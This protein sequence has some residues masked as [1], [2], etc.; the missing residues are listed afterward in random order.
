MHG[1]V[2]P[3]LAAG[4][5]KSTIA[6]TLG[7]K[8]QDLMPY[9]VGLAASDR[10]VVLRDWACASERIELALSIKLQYAPM[11]PYRLSVIALLDESEARYQAITCKHLWATSQG[12][13]DEEFHPLT[14][15]F[16]HGD[17][18]NEFDRFCN[19]EPMRTLPTLRLHRARFRCIPV[20]ERSIEQ[21]HALAKLRLRSNNVPSPAS[22]S[23]ALRLP[24]WIDLVRRSSELF[25]SMSQHVQSIRRLSQFVDV[26]G[27]RT[28]KALNEAFCKQG[29]LRW[30]DVVKVLYH[31]D[32]DTTFHTRAQLENNLRAAEAHKRKAAQKLRKQA[33]A[34]EPPDGLPS[35]SKSPTGPFA[36]Q[37]HHHAV[38]H[39][40]AQSAQGV[41]YSCFLHGAQQ[42]EFF[43]D[44]LCPVTKQ[45]SHQHKVTRDTS[46]QQRQPPES[47]DLPM[48][49]ESEV[50]QMESKQ[51]VSLQLVTGNAMEAFELIRDSSFRAASLLP[52]AMM[53]DV[54][55]EDEQR[56]MHSTPAFVF[57]VLQRNPSSY[58]VIT[59][60]PRMNTL[61]LSDTAIT[62]H[63]AAGFDL[64]A[65]TVA[66][67]ACPSASGALSILLWAAPRHD[68][69]AALRWSVIE[70]H[71]QMDQQLGIDEQL[72]PGCALTP[73]QR[74]LV[75]KLFDAGAFPSSDRIE[76]LFGRPTFATFASEASEE[77]ERKCLKQLADQGLVEQ[78][79]S[80]SE[81]CEW[82]L[83]RLAMSAAHATFTLGPAR[84][85]F[86]G[87]EIC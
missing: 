76:A 2:L 73:A 49:C 56:L 13:G 23:L 25:N 3:E 47:R 37:L 21:K 85:L 14:H 7:C 40:K 63:Y 10:V 24:L 11:L 65:G 38:Q 22:V 30:R 20:L 4:H 71:A 19:G 86:S 83:T 15:M 9:L 84:F 41:F 77:L 61:R 6:A 69:V 53:H 54:L 39:F 59:R 64:G 50:C 45:L 82:R 27:L 66:V 16:F 67:H 42:V 48:E 79:G 55:P 80:S 87:Q 28:H 70:W 57:R 17:I 35:Q 52:P 60:G 58:K 62:T 44:R 29:R 81:R 26:V 18:A 1:R 75:H 36:Q 34:Q 68:S 74:E 8:L 78:L 46:A 5:W 51:E 31:C 72:L 33:G 43:A 32:V 12:A